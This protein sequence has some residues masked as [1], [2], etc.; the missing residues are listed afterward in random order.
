MEVFLYKT[1]WIRTSNNKYSI[2]KRSLEIYETH[3]TVMNYGHQLTQIHYYDFIKEF[4][5]ENKGKCEWNAVHERIKTLVKELF[6]SVALTY[7]QMATENVY[8]N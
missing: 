1:F 6:V 3:F 4:D 8:L 5:Q 2:D 7:P